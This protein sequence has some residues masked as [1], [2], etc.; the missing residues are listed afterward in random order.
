MGTVYLAWRSDGLFHRRVAVKVV[1]P[2]LDT[3]D[4]LR[5]FEREREILA[6][7]EHPGI[8]RLLDAG[9]TP[10][11]RPYLVMEHVEGLPLD[12]WCAERR[13]SVEERLRLVLAV[14]DAVEHAHRNLVAHRD[15]KPANILVDAEGRPH[16][17]DFGIARL[18][19]GDE[20]GD[21]TRLGGRPMTPGYASPEQV[22]GEPV[23]AASDV[24]SLGVLLYE[25]LSGGHPF[26]KEG[27]SPREVET[28]VCDEAPEP[29]SRSAAE[30]R[31]RRR[32]AGDLD[33]V[34]L[35]AVRPEPE[36]RYA[37]VDRLAEDLRRHLEGLPVQAR[38]GEAW[39]RAGR[40]ARRYKSAVAVAL[41]LLAFAGGMAWL[42]AQRARSLAETRSALAR[43]DDE[44]RR[45]AR[46]AELLVDLFRFSDPRDATGPGPPTRPTVTA[47]D[48]LRRGAER[49]ERDLGGEPAI[50]GALLAAVGRAYLN[51]G[52][53]DEAAPLLERSLELRRRASSE[54]HPEVAESL[55]D[56][57]RALRDLGRWA[58]A[59]PL[60][61]RG[62][63]LRRELLGAGHPEAARSL[64]TLGLVLYE[65]G[66]YA[67]AEKALAEAVTLRRRLPPEARAS[68]GESLTNL[69]VA[70]QARG[71]LA[72][73]ESLYREAVALYRQTL[74][75]EHPNLA[76]SLNNLALTVHGLHRAAEAESLLT[77]AL[78]LHRRAFGPDH[79]AVAATLENLAR[80]LAERGEHVRAEALAREALALHRRRFGE[81]HPTV[82]LG[83][84]NLAVLLHTKGDLAE[85][86]L[87]FRQALALRRALLP[88]AHPEIA[89]SLVGLGAVLTDRGRARQARALLEEGLALRR[90]AFPAGHM[91]VAAAEAE[92]G[93]CLADLGQE[94]EAAS[95]LG[96]TV[97]V[98]RQALGEAHPVTRRA[99]ERLARLR[100][101]TS[102]S[103]P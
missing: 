88:P 8:A 100:S 23:T 50:Q 79:P 13:P 25:M 76:T 67:A 14:C 11:G 72:G 41:L 65:K 19:S 63:A 52:L 90:S 1:R 44:A 35:R 57:A 2:G 82:A 71:D 17:L 16:L 32:L 97:P 92:L 43:A 42:A 103:A 87:H 27:R 80:V 69:A 94:K 55:D 10:A 58:E 33:A 56:L 70:R 34:V 21:L 46:T 31:L 5:R 22:R 24:W 89:S 66:E 3:A 64:N 20:R 49:V 85:A 40:L 60:A 30:P 6:R 96:R 54:R 38:G 15:L 28:A 95:L 48:V 101:A 36:R 18:L 83:V 26:R 62:L 4:V 12:R 81:R 61:R 39:Y 45:A 78:E 29:P 59:E 7:L 102:R 86:E 84:N 74:G 53:P 68:L 98:L 91:R 9:Q 93:R 75:P 73:A 37:S 77:E 51:L 47:Q 99:A